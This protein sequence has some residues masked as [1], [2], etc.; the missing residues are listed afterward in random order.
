MPK[1]LLRRALPAL[2]AGACALPLAHADIY[3]WTDDKGRVNISNVEPPAGAHVTSVLRE[4]KE[5]KA[6]NEAARAAALERLRE[7]EVQAL[8][9]RVRQLQ[10]EV[11]AAKRPPPAPVVA[12]APP[13]TYAYTGEFAPP[14]VQYNV[15][16]ASP[17]M[18]GGYGNSGC[19][20]GWPDCQFGWYPGFY[21][22]YYPVSIVVPRDK[23]FRRDHFQPKPAPH[24]RGPTAPW[25]PVPV[26]GGNRG[27]GR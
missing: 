26:I 1:P 9:E 2:I 25:S 14:V 17:A 5:M 15:I 16:N 12:A 24:F 4:S 7:A 10:A 21:P 6:A 11:E 22:A 23:H 27:R 20:T 8:A 13:P 18:G 19:N 3:T